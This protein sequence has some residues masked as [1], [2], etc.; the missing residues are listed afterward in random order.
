MTLTGQSK[1]ITR[2]KAKNIVASNHSACANMP[3]L[4]PCEAYC[5]PRHC[6]PTCA[7]CSF[8]PSCFFHPHMVPHNLTHISSH[9]PE[10]VDAWFRHQ[11]CFFLCF[12][13][14]FSNAASAQMELM[15]TPTYPQKRGQLECFCVCNHAH[16]PSC[17]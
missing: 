14:F 4:I 3:Y 13:F 9:P 15:L 12:F 11:P 5:Q 16:M 1:N 10:P 8:V 2:I 17:L 6:F 7:F